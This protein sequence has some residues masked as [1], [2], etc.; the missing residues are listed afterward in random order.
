MSLKVIHQNMTECPPSLKKCAINGSSQ[1]SK[2]FF[3]IIIFFFKGNASQGRQSLGTQLFNSFRL[4]GAI[5]LNSANYG[6]YIWSDGDLCEK[7]TLRLS[8]GDLNLPTYLPM[9]Q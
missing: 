4:Q 8:N 1:N 2:R 9:R 5:R 7:V 6:K 3:F